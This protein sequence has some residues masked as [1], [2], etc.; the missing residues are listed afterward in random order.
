MINQYNQFL[1]NKILEE[2]QGGKK[3][4]AFIKL[5]NYINENKR[6]Y[7]ALYNYG[8]MAEQFGKIDT[9][10]KSYK[11]VSKN[12]KNNWRAR[13]N[14]Y[15]IYFHK[16]EYDKSLKLVNSV[17]E[18][19]PNFQ[20]ALR[21][22][23]HIYFHTKK[24][25]LALKLIIESIDLNKKDY[26]A[27]NILGMIYLKLKK[28]NEAKESFEHA[29]SL[30][31]E[32]FP[33][34]NNLGNC[35]RELNL[36][37]EALKNYKKS[38]IINPSFIEAI[39]N[40]GSLL[41]E[42]GNFKDGIDV[43]NKALNLNPQNSSKNSQI[44]LNLAIGYFFNDEIKNA[45]KFFK[46]SEK[47]DPE[48]DKFK[49]N[50]S[51]FLLYLQ[52]YR[53]AWKIID[54]RLE[55]KEFNFPDSYKS[56]LNKKLWKGEE[57]K[58]HDKILIIKEQGIG[59]EILYSSMYPDL[60]NQY[61][62]ITIETEERLLSLFKRSFKN[63][64]AFVPY[65]SISKDSEK[66]KNFDKIIFSGSLGKIYRN[67]LDNF[68]QRPFLICDQNKKIK[69][70]KI[71][72]N[73]S[74]KPKIGIGWKSKREFYGSSKS[75]DLD[76]MNSFL[77]ISDLTYINLQYGDVEKDTENLKTK[78]NIEI[79]SI[80]EIDL[81][82]DFE[83]ISSLLINLDLFI[84][85]SN[86]TAHLSGALGIPTWL[87][88]PKRNAQFHYWNQPSN[89]TPWYSSIEIFSQDED[90]IKTIELIKNQLLIRFNL[91]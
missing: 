73:I 88:K 35:F 24:L 81:F 6:D 64:N 34:Y 54:G 36:R 76:L 62:R 91:N 89:K 26:I 47:I 33:S 31:S 40:T 58:T 27:L 11:I 39:N 23:A 75:I 43:L 66:I 41:I 46:I 4:E 59:D 71:L 29:I 55:L 70:K 51:L 21:D 61:P 84:T 90:P 74:N 9:A 30:N 69:I 22:K 20:P 19:K 14:L 25:D 13:F 52:K 17:L 3:Q 8:Y 32:Y 83:K 56:N 48:N 10:I 85:V 5:E 37:E 53:E 77:S 79:T 87:I 86:S 12:E 16:Q 60:I 63:E 44:N 82:N 80:P 57:I 42:I 15:L 38:S 50:Y 7:A 67:S 65:L 18:I 2:F 78:Y 28:I 45:E 1:L 72:D 68:P 49:K